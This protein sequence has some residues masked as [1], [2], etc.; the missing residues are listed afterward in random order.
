MFIKNLFKRKKNQVKKENSNGLYTPAD[1]NCG[2]FGCFT[3]TETKKKVFMIKR[4][5]INEGE[6]ETLVDLYES[7][8]KRDEGWNKLVLSHNNMVIDCYGVDLNHI[9][10]TTFYYEWGNDSLTFYD[11]E[12]PSIEQTF[13]EKDWAYIEEEK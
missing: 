4:T 10:E 11:K 2:C 9:D 8:R 5:F 1:C 13:Y 7:E 6:V 12:D 3:V